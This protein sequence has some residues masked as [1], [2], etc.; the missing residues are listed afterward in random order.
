M[1]HRKQ[2]CRG[3]ENYFQHPRCD[4]NNEKSVF[5]VGRH[6]KKYMSTQTKIPTFLGTPLDF[7]H[8]VFTAFTRTVRVSA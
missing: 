4:G 2:A 3:T 6:T 5:D 8:R 1:M 7:G